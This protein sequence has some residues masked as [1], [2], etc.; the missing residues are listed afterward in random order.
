M[1]KLKSVVAA[2]AISFSACA[3]NSRFVSSWKAPDATPLDFRGAKVVAVV[4]MQNPASRREAEDTLAREITKRGA[5]GVALYTIVDDEGIKDDATSRAALEGAEV[6]GAVVMRP[7]G[8]DKE[9][10]STPS[11]GGP[12]YG[13]YYGGYS[14]YGWGSAWPG[15]VYTNTIVSVETLVY[16]LDQNK[17]VWGGQSETTNPDNVDELVKDLSAAV[18]EELQKEGLISK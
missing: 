1:T 2:L 5:Q 16:S 15:E 14:A 9:V 6:K 3:S 11:Y 17:L 4:M 12:M 13:S 18:T 7:M 8:T 10:V